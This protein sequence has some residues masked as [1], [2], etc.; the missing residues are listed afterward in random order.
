MPHLSKV[1]SYALVVLLV[2]CVNVM[3]DMYEDRGL[4]Q[5]RPQSA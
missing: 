1:L 2:E 3:Q 4:Q 5:A